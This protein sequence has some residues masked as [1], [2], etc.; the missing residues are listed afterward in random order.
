MVKF[1]IK[2]LS[3]GGR[4]FL[5]G[6]LVLGIGW[7]ILSV[8][9]QHILVWRLEQQVV[10]LFGGPAVPR[11]GALDGRRVSVKWEP[12]A[13]EGLGAVD[14]WLSTHG[15]KLKIL[16]VPSRSQMMEFGQESL[17]GAIARE[18]AQRG[19]D[20]LDSGLLFE[21][22]YRA[23][24]AAPIFL[25]ETHLGLAGQ[26]LVRRIVD[27]ALSKLDAEKRVVLAGDCTVEG[28]AWCRPVSIAVRLGL[29]SASMERIDLM[30]REGRANAIGANLVLYDEDFWKTHP[31][32]I[33]VLHDYYFSAKPSF[34]RFSIPR[35][36]SAKARVDVQ[37]L[38]AR[39]L[40]V[41]NSDKL[42]L[43]RGPYPDALLAIQYQDVVSG[44]RFTGIHQLMTGHRILEAVD[45]E[46]GDTI[47]MCRQEWMEAQR[48]QPAL[49]KTQIVDDTTDF[50][51]SVFWVKEWV[52]VWSGTQN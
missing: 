18:L 31:L 13:F 41:S 11:D 19:L 45:I 14:H 8:F 22:F 33:W 32:V 17:T 30:Y 51:Q 46:P 34:G 39:V 23:A 29:A 6:L 48:M 27:E 16:I 44:E 49:A 28:V 12:S 15:V 35:S 52:K 42:K 7:A 4:L 2:N 47:R 21:R 50:E 24:G 43:P 3:L 40:Y 9:A 37:M 25:D 20:V 26:L 36:D 38:G 10:P 1:S 5:A